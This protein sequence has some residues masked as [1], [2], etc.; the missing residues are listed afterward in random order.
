MRKELIELKKQLSTVRLRK[1]FLQEEIEVKIKEFD[2]FLR[3]EV[4]LEDRIKELINE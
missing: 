4:K 2:R 3:Q 1:V